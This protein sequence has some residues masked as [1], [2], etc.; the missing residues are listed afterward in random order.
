[1]KKRTFAT[2]LI[3]FVL[4][5]V[6]V[7]GAVLM[8]M[9]VEV[10]AAASYTEK[11]FPRYKGNSGLVSALKSLK[12][13]S[14]YSYRERIAKAN[15][16][17]NYRG[18]ANQNTQ[19]LK[20]LKNGKLLN[21][22]Y[23]EP[24]PEIV[25]DHTYYP[26]YKGKS[27]SIS[28]A[29]KSLGI[30]GSYAH[31]ATIAAANNI[32]NYRGTASQNLAMLSLL[33][34]GRLK[35]P[36]TSVAITATYYDVTV[37]TTLRQQPY[38]ASSAVASIP[39]NSTV[40][41]METVKN[42]YGNTWYKVLFY[43]SEGVKKGYI[44]SG[45]VT[46]H[47][48]KY[49]TFEFNEITYKVCECGAVKTSARKQSKRLEGE[50]VLAS[51][52]L[53]IPLAATDGPFPVG[54]LIGAGILIVGLCLAHDVAVPALTD[55]AEMITE[56]DFDEY[57]KKRE[58]VCSKHSF[59]MVA[60]AGKNLVC[61]GKHCLDFMEAYIYCRYLGGNVY[62]L[63]ENN[64]LILATMYITSENGKVV[65]ERNKHQPT[66]F[67]H[68]HFCEDRNDKWCKKRLNGHIFFDTNDFGMTP[69]GFAS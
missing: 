43:S 61:I 20:L 18:T 49:R 13:D 36:L 53:A 14:S 44:Y 40:V 17:S 47:D 3:A 38:E 32:K 50:Q 16:I 65:M 60:V 30:D 33:K 5:V 59:R 37:G 24:A 21:P 26:A 54:D 39:K 8:A 66:Y 41:A 31:R 52:S 25:I 45:K 10:E 56:V 12:I 63:D 35:R 27:G 64:A 11:Y 2:Q 9:P 68:Y 19:I 28:T 48:H 55:L 6:T 7:M 51:V 22:D 67:F 69:V 23:R 34:I 42:K 1:M 46:Q 57:L 62:T 58:N 29:L 4:A 15:S